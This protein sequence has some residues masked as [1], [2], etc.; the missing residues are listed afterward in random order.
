MTFSNHV[1]LEYFDQSGLRKIYDIGTGRGPF[2]TWQEYA[3]SELE[4][5]YGSYECINNEL[6]KVIAFKRNVTDPDSW[7]Q[8]IDF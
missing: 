7:F 1:L 2:S 5:C 4:F 3:Q 6:I 8:Y